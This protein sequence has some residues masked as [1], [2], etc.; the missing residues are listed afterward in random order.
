MQTMQDDINAK[1]PFD[2]GSDTYIIKY[3]T[4]CSEVVNALSKKERK[5]CM[6]LVTEWNEVGP[7]RAVQLKCAINHE[8]T[9]ICT[10]LSDWCQASGKIWPSG[11]QIHQ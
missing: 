1:I 3:P 9:C 10:D 2:P 11:K 7:P 8:V 5:E 4:A 6:K